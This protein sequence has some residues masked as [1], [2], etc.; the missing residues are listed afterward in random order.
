MASHT[1]IRASGTRIGEYAK[2]IVLKDATNYGP[3]RAKLT[4]ILG[5]E[6]CQDIVNGIELEPNEIGTIVDMDDATK[7]KT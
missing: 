7:N 5:A 3:W 4:S 2:K 6:D 1:G